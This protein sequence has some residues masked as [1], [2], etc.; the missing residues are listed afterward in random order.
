[1]LADTKTFY[2]GLPL[3]Q[4]SRGDATRTETATGLANGQLTYSA[5]TAGYD[6]LGRITYDGYGR[7]TA[8]WQPG[9]DK[10]TQSPSVKYSYTIRADGPNA[11]TTQTL[12]PNGTDYLTSVELSDGLGRDV[13]TQTQSMDQ[14]VDANG[15]VSNQP[16]RLVA[17]TRYDLR[18]LTV[19][20]QQPTFTWGL[21]DTNVQHI[22]D[23]VVN[24][25]TKTT[26]DGLGR[27]TKATLF[28]KNVEK[29]STSTVYEGDRTHVTPPP[30]GT[31]T[32]TITD[33]RGQTTAVRQYTGAPLSTAFDETRYSYTPASKIKTH[34]DPA[35]NTWTYNYNLQG[36]RTSGDDPDTGRSSRTY[37][38]AGQMLTSTNAKGE[39]L[40]YTYDQLGRKTSLRDDN[41]G[42]AVRASWD[43]DTLK[44]GQA[45][46]STRWLDGKA[47]VSKITGYDAASR[48]TGTQII[49]PEIPN[50]V[51]TPLAK[52]YTSAMTYTPGGNPA[53]TTL[54]GYGPLTFEKFN[55][56]YDAVGRPL[57]LGGRGAYVI[58][59]IYSGDN[60]LMQLATGN[61]PGQT[62]WMTYTYDEATNRQ[63]TARFDREVGSKPDAQ[64]S[65]TYNP[66]GNLTK[67][68]TATPESG[69]PTDTQ[70][71]NTD[72]LD[73]LT[74]AWT[75][76][77]G[78]CDTPP[79][80]AGL[81]GP[82]PYWMDWTFDKA[83]NRTSETQRAAAGDVTS[84][85]TL[86][87][88]G[89]GPKPHQ[90]TSQTIRRPG[91][92]EVTSPITYDP[93][94][95]VTARTTTPGSLP[96]QPN[97]PVGQTLGYNREGR[98]DSITQDGETVRFAYNS[99]GERLIRRDNTTTVLSLGDT[100][101][102]LTRATGI[103]SPK[104]YVQFA[105]KTVAMRT[106][107]NDFDVYTLWSDL[108]NT[109][110]WQV[111]NTTSAVTTQR[112]TPYGA[113]RDMATRLAS[114][115][116]FV[117]GLNDPALG[118]VRIGARDY[119]PAT[120]RFLQPDP[121][122]DASSSSTQW[123]AYGYGNN[124]PTDQPDPTGLRPDDMDGQMY[125]RYLQVFN[126]SKKKGY[127]HTRSQMRANNAAYNTPSGRAGGVSW[128]QSYGVKGVSS[129]AY[130]EMGEKYRNA[131]RGWTAIKK[132][133]PRVYNSAKYSN[134][135]WEIPA[136]L[137]H[138]AASA[139]IAYD[140]QRTESIFSSTYGA[141]WQN[142]P[143]DHSLV[144]VAY[145]RL[146]TL[147]QLVSPN[148]E[149]DH[150]PYISATLGITGEERNKD[151]WLGVS[152]IGKDS[153]TAYYDVYSNIAFGYFGTKL[154]FP[155]NVLIL[156][157]HMRGAGVTDPGDDVSVRMGVQM[158]RDKVSPSAENVES[159]IQEKVNSVD[160]KGKIQPG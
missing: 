88:N 106:S 42:G 40:A 59:T 46:S 78:N 82:A 131:T 150:K 109:T 3:G 125:T 158:A 6:A 31:A 149:L 12:H 81:G 1:M 75:P 48:P 2:D 143:S 51:E 72:H 79:T 69:A 135:R 89:A 145:R 19:A 105:G 83:S 7:I 58:N 45:T 126:G 99:D 114:D 95:N 115:R 160:W 130:K 117:Q 119:D 108:N 98:L 159:Y 65:Y 129:K 30:G 96:G 27:P 132:T 23:A 85:W 57:Q 155:S 10:A 121:I 101:L 53:T 11:V 80:V 137:R 76:A 154:G 123:N 107:S 140:M 9:R 33:A 133:S 147:S 14:A 29:W 43:Y 62:A 24:Q 92:P 38:V 52:T 67:L 90:V 21:P 56:T 60:K 15:N 61:T 64:L 146:E 26:F 118:M 127:S 151:S 17:S 70:C 36:Q 91:Q 74:R 25:V 112:T 16:G 142:V 134:G 54:T 124:N 22:D 141:I 97:T 71:Y 139:I 4:I 103:I 35:G 94:G 47:I 8:V 18:G 13:Q 49:L 55:Y 111:Q 28:S 66:A 41:P 73:R 153:R 156:G 86:P 128:K 34:T 122:L 148:A 157:S 68:A 113:P 136:E 84:T 20:Q 50:W 44:K 104:R 138:A 116:G 152:K 102:T 110:A 93:A 39:T 37:D 32:T 77:G 5:A 63:A 120:G 87:A 100:E 144:S